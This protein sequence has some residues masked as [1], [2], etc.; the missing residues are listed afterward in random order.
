MNNNLVTGAS[1]LSSPVHLTLYNEW[2]PVW[3]EVT[4][5]ALGGLEV[6][7][8]PSS[9]GQ[10]ILHE[11]FLKGIHSQNGPQRQLWEKLFLCLS[12]PYKRCVEPHWYFCWILLRKARD[13]RAGRLLAVWTEAI[14]GK[15]GIVRII[16]LIV[17][18]P[19]SAGRSWKQ[20]WIRQP[21]ARVG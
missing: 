6:T 1:T 4:D 10:V 8:W 3:L 13:P 9:S 12:N 16:Y 21:G 17:G 15:Y 5:S 18:W 11:G 19:N 7:R 2:A 14:R 20:Q